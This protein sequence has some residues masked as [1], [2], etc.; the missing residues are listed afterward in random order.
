MPTLKKSPRRPWRPKHEPFEGF[1]HHNTEFYQ[2]R[3]WRALRA[4]KLQQQPLCE[5][6]LRKGRMTPA[7]MVD[8]IVAAIMALGEWMT[9]QA[10]EDNDPYNQRGM[11]RF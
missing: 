2:S 4:M 3:R 11:L 8:H 6:C 9:A 5:E 1:T 10:A 7:E